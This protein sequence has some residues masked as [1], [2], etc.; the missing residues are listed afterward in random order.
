MKRTIILISAIFMMIFMTSCSIYKNDNRINKNTFIET[1]SEQRI[2]KDS[3]KEISSLDIKI[4]KENLDLKKNVGFIGISDENLYLS[5][6][7]NNTCSFLTYNYVIND[8]IKELFTFKDFES[9]VLYDTYM[10]NLY[11]G[12]LNYQDNNYVIKIYEIINSSEYKLIYEFISPKYPLIKL[13]HNNIVCYY[14]TYQNDRYTDLLVYYNIDTNKSNII[15][16]FEYNISEDGLYTGNIGGAFGGNKNGLY[17]LNVSLDNEDIFSDDTGICTVNY[18]SFSDHKIKEICNVDKKL[19]FLSGGD[20]FF[21]T[22]D[23]ANK[24]PEKDKSTG[25]LYLIDGSNIFLYTIPKIY[26]VFEDDISGIYSLDNNRVV[27]YNKKNIYIYNFQ[28]KE[29]YIYKY[30]QTD[31][32]STYFQDPKILDN[33]IIYLSGNKEQDIS[34][35]YTIEVKK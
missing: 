19:R 13:I 3:M 1:K 15:N 26:P 27:I 8:S 12:V 7:E 18:Y 24:L 9:L 35:L 34:Y 33:N 20:N 25:K 14:E 6:S 11:V 32:S 5:Y 16:K 29:Y 4:K 17:F 30:N 28:N 21:V 10:N 23:Y 31:D 2:I 22:S